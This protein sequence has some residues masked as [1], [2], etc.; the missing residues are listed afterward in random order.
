MKRLLYWL[1]LLV[2]MQLKNP[3]IVTVL[4]AMPVAAFIITHTASLKEAEPVRVGIVLEDDDM[5]AVLTRDYLINGDYSVEFYEAESQ[6]K[7]EQDIM[8]K[9]AEC[10]YIVSTGLKDKLDSG[11]YSDVIELII[12][13]SDFVSSMTDEIFFSAMF[14]AYSPE[15]AVNYVNSVEKFQKHAEKAEEEIRKGYEEY[16]SGDDTFRIDF[17]VI[18]G[19]QEAELQLEDKTGQFPLRALFMI[20]VYISGFFGI[21]EYY[22]DKNSGTF[23]TLPRMYRI[24]GKPVYAFIS[25]VLFAVSA[26]ITL[27]VAGQLN[28]GTDILHMTVYVIAVTLFAWLVAILVRSTSTMISI[29]P[30]LLIACL[31]LC[32]VFVN[33]TA[34]VPFT[35]YIRALLLP[36]Y[37]L[38]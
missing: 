5:I 2:K 7:L 15:V 36:W 13:K 26:I 33:I 6:E 18:D 14:K 28:G 35:K 11:S 37:M 16:I 8:N 12:C 31:I 1:Y 22:F 30:V 4:I 34:Y 38:R 3:V 24:A 32:P 25:C 9:R 21:V 20:L 19:T 23:I 17:K 29:I 27:A 10:G